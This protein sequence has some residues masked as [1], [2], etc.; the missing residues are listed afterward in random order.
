MVPFKTVLIIQTCSQTA[1]KKAIL[2]AIFLDINYGLPPC[3]A[4]SI[5]FFISS[6]RFDI[7]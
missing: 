3:L 2:C 5:S 4:L 6:A 1:I 7:F